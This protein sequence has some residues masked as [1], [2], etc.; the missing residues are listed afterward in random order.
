MISVNDM[1]SPE[2]KNISQQVKRKTVDTA[3]WTAEKSTYV[4]LP[5]AAVI[6]AFTPVTLAVAAPFMALD[7]AGYLL[8]RHKR[9]KRKSK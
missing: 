3:L 2:N 1:A 6:V 5:T 4:T 8:F 9:N 7:G